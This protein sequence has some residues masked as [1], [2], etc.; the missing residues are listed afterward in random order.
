[1]YMH[2]YYVLRFLFGNGVLS[3][4]ADSS[5]SICL[6]RLQLALTGSR[7]TEPCTLSAAAF[8]KHCWKYGF[9]LDRVEIQV[10]S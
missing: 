1:M 6:F 4:I 3:I 2:A 9:S 8:V 5:I 10:H 7:A